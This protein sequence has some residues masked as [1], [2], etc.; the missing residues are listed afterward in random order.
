MARTPAAKRKRAERSRGGATQVHAAFC[1]TCGA[2]KTLKYRGKNGQKNN[3]ALSPEA[4]RHFGAVV[5]SRGRGNLDVVAYISPDEAEGDLY[6]M[7]KQQLLIGLQ[8]WL[9]RGWLT[10]EDLQ[11]II[12]ESA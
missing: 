5:Q 10:P 11:A 7:V 4:R 12:S 1:P 8:V 6:L 9:Q 3:W 2:M